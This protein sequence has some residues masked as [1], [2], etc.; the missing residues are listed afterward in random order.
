MTE[1]LKENALKV[2]DAICEDKESVEIDGEKYFV[3][4]TSHTGLNLL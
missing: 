3:K 1:S 4:R 2:Y